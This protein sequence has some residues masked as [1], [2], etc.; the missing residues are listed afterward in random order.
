M[1]TDI[2]NTFKINLSILKYFSKVTKKRDAYNDG[3][4]LFTLGIGY[5]LSVT[6]AIILAATGIFMF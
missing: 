4:H 6:A 3:S 1:A 5:R 2:Y